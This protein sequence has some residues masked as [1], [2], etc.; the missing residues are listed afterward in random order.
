FAGDLGCT[1]TSGPGLALKS[2]FLGLAVMTELPLVVFDIMR[3]GPSTG[4]PTKTEQADLTQALY[5]RSGEAPLPVLAAQSPADCFHAAYEAVDVATRFMTP[6]IVLS[7]VYLANGAEPWLIPKAEELPEIHIKFAQPDEEFAP[8]LRDKKTLARKWAIPGTPNLQHRIGGLEKENITGSVSYDSDNHEEMVELRA[9]K[10]QRVGDYVKE[11]EIYG[12]EKGDVLIISWGS[13]YG[14]VLTVVEK[15]R[16][17][18]KKVSFYHLR[19]IN[20]MPRSIE[21][22]IHNFKHVL[23]PEVNAGQL[24]HLIRSKFLVDAKGFNRT[25]GLPLRVGELKKEIENLI[26]E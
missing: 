5:G 16:N 8:Y 25:K 7:D 2:E 6:V 19:W 13:T 22:Y 3:G 26:G 1:S 11:P 24:I 21:K 18:G 17:E 9:E 10:V 15:L 4:M 14:V 12:E 23:V 20:P